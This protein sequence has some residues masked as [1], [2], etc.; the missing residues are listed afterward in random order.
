MLHPGFG[1]LL[2]GAPSFDR[3]P[4]S[5]LLVDAPAI[6]QPTERHMGVLGEEPPRQ[7]ERRARV[8]LYESDCVR[9][10][11]YLGLARWQL[12]R[13]LAGADH[14]LVVGLLRR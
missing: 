10:A 12:E 9:S 13:L 6:E 14:H 5:K 1:Q 2:R 3:L 7:L 11:C 4:R 8:D